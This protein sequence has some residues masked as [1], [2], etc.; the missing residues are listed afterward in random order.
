LFFSTVW[1]SVSKFKELKHAFFI[2]GISSLAP[3]FTDSP[4]VFSWLLL[5]LFILA[6]FNEKFWEKYWLATPLIIILWA[7]LHGSFPEALIILLVILI[8]KS[9]REKRVWIKGL[10]A[11]F[12][13]FLATFVNPYGVKLWWIIWLTASDSFI[14][15]R[16]AEWQ[17]TYVNPFGFSFLALFLFTISVVFISKYWHKFRSEQIVLN[18]I[19]FI[20]AILAIRNI[21]L[22]ALVDLPMVII[23]INYFLIEVK[24]NKKGKEKLEIIS[25]GMF[26]FVSIIFAFQC[27][28]FVHQYSGALKETLFYP[29]NAVS[30]L[31]TNLPN[32]QIFS[33]YNWGGYLIWKLPEKKVFIYGMMPSWVWNS[34]AS[35]ESNNAMSDYFDTLAGKT[36]YKTVFDKYNIDTALLSVPREQI[37]IT[38]FAEKIVRFLGVKEPANT[39]DPLYK[40]LE[41]D[42]WV[43]TYIDATSIVLKRPISVFGI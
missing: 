8:C 17:P 4:K 28:E 12:L 26:L 34:G 11:T 24:G 31:E 42:G 29:K 20:Q 5:S 25:K 40:E 36:P 39:A 9:I 21:T 22:W 6:V 43:Q 19:F 14:K 37:S 27:F 15:F 30:Y 7:N 41:K 32:G 2:V 18:L 38:G 3:F 1:I 13:S 23:A 16:I 35:S 33:E 10:L